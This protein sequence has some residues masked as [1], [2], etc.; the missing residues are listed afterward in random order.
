MKTRF[1]YL[2]RILLVTSILLAACSGVD[3]TEVIPETGIETTVITEAPAATAAV[4]Q[5]A[6][7]TGTAARPTATGAAAGG[8][9]GQIGGSV[10]VMGV[11]GGEEM[12]NF[13]AML[14][15]FEEQT[16]IDV[17]YLRTRDITTTLADRIQ[18]G[19]LPDIA[20][21][22]NPGAMR[23]YVAQG[24]LTPLDDV[25]D[26]TRMQQEYPEG[27][28]DLAQVDG[29]IYGVFIKATVKNLVW[30]RP[31]VFQERGYQVPQTWEELQSL[32]Q[33]IISEGVAPWCIGVETGW[34]GTDWIEGLMLHT[35]APETYDAWSEHSIPWTDPAVADAWK[36]W[37]RIVGDPAM[38]YGGP[39]FVLS[40]NSG[41]AAFNL[42]DEE[43]GCFLY[44]QASFITTFITEQF[45]DVR[46]GEGLNFFPF[47]PINEQNGNP[48]LV[49]GDLF[50]IFNDTPQ[51]R[52]LMEYLTTAEAQTIWAERG[53]YIAPNRA[54]SPDVYP[55]DSTRAV[56]Q[57]YVEAESVRFDASDLM[58]QAVQ[59]AFTQG[60]LQ[61]VEDPGSLPSILENI[62]AIAQ[63]ADER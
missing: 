30:Y 48:L 16:G 37:G 2:W 36:A 53:G 27:F 52:A 44:Y 8:A 17:E 40:N 39:P 46:L 11:W 43:P 13:Q 10:S 60:V 33:Q 55:D 61:F 24:A 26:A 4:T 3:A 12:D 63:E 1:G 57:S 28:T 50:G 34:P 21:I 38:V 41:E 59:E 47:P 5:E 35:A 15:S 54:V 62:E 58:P 20:G 49:A 9:A 45:P 51:A 25:L 23:Q 19:V 6:A 18:G 22:P 29:Q 31:D 14:A 32:E 42:F 7:A 56:A